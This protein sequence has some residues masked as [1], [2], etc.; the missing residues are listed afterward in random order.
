MQFPPSQEEMSTA[1]AN[2]KIATFIDEKVEGSLLGEYLN[3]SE[4]GRFYNQKTIGRFQPAYGGTPQSGSP[5]RPVQFENYAWE[6]VSAAANSLG[7]DRKLIRNKRDEGIL[8]EISIE[9][10]SSFAGQSISN[11]EALSWFEDKP[12]ELQFPRPFPF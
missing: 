11:K 5:S 2:N 1:Y 10:F 7:C 4:K 6:S 9:A 8:R 3:S 12:E